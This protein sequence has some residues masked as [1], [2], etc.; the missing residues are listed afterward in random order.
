MTRKSAAILVSIAFLVI[1]GAIG[2]TWHESKQSL[3]VLLLTVE[4]LRADAVTQETTPNLLRLAA[5]HGIR[6]SEHRAVSAWTGT[7]IVTLLTGWT[8]FQHRVHSRGQ[9][10]SAEHNLA[11][12]TIADAG[13][14]V[15]GLQAFMRVP[16][17]DQLGLA[18]EGI[19]AAEN[20]PADW[21][22]A[23][24]GDDES[25]VLWDHYLHTHL[26][27]HPSADYEPEWQAMLPAV[28]ES[29]K[30]A[31]DARFAALRTLGKIDKGSVEFQEDE[32]D[33]IDALYHAGVREFDAWFADLW[34]GLEATGLLDDTVII[35]TADHG[36]EILE[37]GHIGHASTSLAGH[38]H[39]EIVRLPLFVFLPT[40]ISGP[41]PGEVIA[42][43]SDHG[44]IMPT[45]LAILGIDGPPGLLGQD[46]RALPEQRAWLAATSLAGYSEVDPDNPAAMI[47]AAKDGRWKLHRVEPFGGEATHRL[48][49]LVDDPG[50][51]RDVADDHADIVDRLA[52][53]IGASRRMTPPPP[54]RP[55]SMAPPGPRP[56]WLRPTAS[57]VY[58]FDALDGRFSLQWSG[59]A[60]RDFVIE[61][62]YDDGAG[63]LDGTIPVHGPMHDFGPIERRYW[64]TWIVP[65]G[66][67][68]V[69]VGY[70]GPIPN[71]S[72]WLEL[73]A[74]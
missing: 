16:I 43:P 53:M 49:D 50:E 57:G 4:S 24:A 60:A 13:W 40:R 58:G 32:R 71:W 63:W 9:R 1:L 30:P 11:L 64:D 20:L 48:Y 52:T 67:Y 2:E 26:P 21:L 61:Y 6:F 31:R 18:R 15:S 68:R 35:V 66:P 37:R 23:R 72:E 39:E 34:T 28:A 45:I 3:N 29:D 25:F 44:D 7:N 19:G 36:D 46:L 42:W 14:R 62:R 38:L 73:R 65:N 51:L 5:A 41:R 70:P 47:T 74:E 59:E 33:A 10:I 55:D 17:F 69:R 56:T 27:Y 22:A 12:E 54:H 8:P